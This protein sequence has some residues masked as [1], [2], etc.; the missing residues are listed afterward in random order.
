[1]EK[2]PLEQRFWSKVDKTDTCWNWTGALSK[3]GYGQI[4]VRE[5]HRPIIAS[6][7]AWELHRGGIADGLFV[8][9]HCDNPRC[10]RPDHLFLGTISDNN[11]DAGKK[12]RSR[13]QKYPEQQSGDRNGRAKLTWAIVDEIRS[14]ENSIHELAEKFHVPYKLIWR[15]RAGETWT[16]HSNV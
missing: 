14:S 7:V 11:K 1:M 15:V 13:T 4:W 9:H 3:G 5:H 10:V 6:R 2:A 16:R 8:C 12:G